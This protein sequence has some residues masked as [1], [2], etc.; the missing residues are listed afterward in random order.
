MRLKTA[1]RVVLAVV[2]AVLAVA[3]LK[4]GAGLPV[5]VVPLDRLE[6]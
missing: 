6:P 2:L 1:G 3:L 4:T 5:L